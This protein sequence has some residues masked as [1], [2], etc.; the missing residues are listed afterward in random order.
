MTAPRSPRAT[1]TIPAALSVMVLSACSPSQPSADAG[2]AA[3]DSAMATCDPWATDASPPAAS[4]R[5]RIDLS[6]CPPTTGG[7]R[8]SSCTTATGCT[9]IYDEPQDTE[10]AA[11]FVTCRVSDGRCLVTFDSAGAPIY[12]PCPTAD[13]PLNCYNNVALVDVRASNFVCGANQPCSI[14][15]S[16]GQRTV[17]VQRTIDGALSRTACPT[18]CLPAA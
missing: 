11:S 10:F 18:E 13:L 17:S 2:D 12:E 8:G 1:L 7:A 16:F 6:P 3:S 9:V 14:E 15:G 5:P 4:V